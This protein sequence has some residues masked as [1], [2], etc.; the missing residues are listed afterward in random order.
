MLEHGIVEDDDAGIIDR[1]L[2]N[3]AMELVV[4]EM[5]ERDVGAGGIG[6]DVALRFHR[7][8]QR[9]GIIGD[10]CAGRRQRGV[11]GGF[12]IFLRGPNNAVPMRTMVAPSSM[13]TSRS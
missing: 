11:E 4:A 13:A 8:E 6:F 10:A 3:F 5:I 12:Q 9:R 7:L 1:A 2:V